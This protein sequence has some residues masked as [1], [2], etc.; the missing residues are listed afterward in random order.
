MFGIFTR[1]RENK[2]IQDSMEI[3]GKA[4]I[5]EEFHSEDAS[6]ISAVSMDILLKNIDEIEGHPWVLA[7]RGM[8]LFRIELLKDTDIDEGTQKIV[9]GLENVIRRS[10]TNAYAHATH[11]NKTILYSRYRSL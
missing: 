6:T 4:L 2:L 9:H 10:D 11:M 1:R 3:I 7:V 8:F 5:L